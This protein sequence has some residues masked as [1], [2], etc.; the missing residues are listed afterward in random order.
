MSL[1]LHS[2]LQR[3]LAACARS[4]GTSKSELVRKLI[5]DFVETRRTGP[6]P[7]ELG[8]DVFGREGSGRRDASVNRKKYL[9]EKLRA[10]T[11]RR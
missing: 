6:T 2:R 5:T 4:H 3:K 7:W 10:G 9:K 8:K 1:R 11:N